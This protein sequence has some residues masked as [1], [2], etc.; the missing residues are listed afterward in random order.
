MIKYE[1]YTE[2]E[3]IQMY[4]QL[5]KKKNA[6]NLKL[7]TNELLAPSLKYLTSTFDNMSVLNLTNLLKS[8]YEM[9]F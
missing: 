8:F 4:Y 1:N 6:K 7:E 2:D 5:S 3:L 9:N